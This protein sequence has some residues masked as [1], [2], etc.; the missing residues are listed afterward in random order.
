MAKQQEATDLQ[1]ALSACK[2]SFVSVGFFS[3][4]VNLLMLVPPMYMLQVYD[5]VL[6]TQSLDTL[7]MLTLVVIFL[8][9]VM[10]GL[11]LVRSRMLV[12]IGNRLDTT[13]NQRLYGAMFRRSLVAPG[14]QSAQPL[15]DLTGLRQFLT[16]NGLFAFFD[17]P[18]VPVYL[19]ILFIFHPWLG[20]FATCAGI[21]LFALAVANEKSTKA[22]L[23][24]ANSEQI[25]AQNLANSNLRNAEVLHAMGMLPGIMGRW[26]KRHH[27]FLAK[28]SQASDR[29]GALTNT[30]KVM[31][32]L[33]Q[34]LILG[35]G[36]LL[37]LQGE[38]TPGMMIAG[39]ILMGRALAPIDQMIGGW[40][41]FVA[42]RGS[43]SRLNELLT[44][45]PD[46]QRHMSLP[47]PK[48]IVDVENVAAAPPGAR[49]ATIRGINFSVAKGE[50]VGIIG[51]SAAGKSTLARV[52][53]GIWPTQV[54][55]VRLDGGAVNQYN[56]DELGPYIG[57]LPQD[58][59]LFDGTI[60]ENIAR[61]GDIDPEK[62]VAAAQ[63]AGVHEMVL[64]LSNGY[65]TVIASNS[66]A[67]SG[68][69][70]QRLGLARALYGNPVL[71]VL[72]EPNANLD[73]AGEKALGQAIAQL[74]TEGTTLF[75]ISHRTSVLKGMDKL[76]VMKEG[77]V[78]MFGPRDQVLA[79]FAKKSRPQVSQ[80]NATRLSAIAGG[81]GNAN[82][83]EETT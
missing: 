74:K 33:F 34:S 15:N 54:G 30:S 55:D 65:D 10:G 13:I 83:S 52:L 56:R 8:F 9:M 51:P 44:Q 77:Q 12:R 28:Q 70:R 32:L 40:K 37:V 45:I 31:R 78:S 19:G 50:H 61:F 81:R 41:G 62:V 39:S 24:E 4:F 3:M 14:A 11:E 53:L 7:I 63:K 76:L 57:Y 71:V 48:G 5:R 75:V 66:G 46:E 22:L 16:G 23:A 49:M 21:I 2:G 1:R 35:L 20:V 18:W 68:G 64:E 79:Q 38:M 73:D 26:S 72:D 25:Q 29:A 17:A 60:S 59:E 58:I 42:A 36:A 82:G 69:Q 80:Q 47:A 6:T 43:Y 27:E 67:L